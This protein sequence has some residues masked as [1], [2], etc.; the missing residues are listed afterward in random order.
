MTLTAL[1][2]LSVALVPSP[3]EF[4]EAQ[5]SFAV[6]S[7]V[8]YSEIDWYDFDRVGQCISE[9][10]KRIVRDPALPREGYRLSVAPDGVSIDAADA[11][12]EFYA[13]VTLRQLA[14][15]TGTNSIAI[16]CCTV[17]D[18]PAYSWRGLLVDEARHFLGK[19]MLLKIIDTMAMHKLN[20]LHW[21]L[22]DDQGWRLVRSRS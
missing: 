9:A 5:G 21:H 17:R 13:L 1:A 12:G 4:A 8:S 11:S 20:V 6:T 18:W 10:K 2:F 16:P 7:R 22:T 14:V 15:Q 19:E 3:R